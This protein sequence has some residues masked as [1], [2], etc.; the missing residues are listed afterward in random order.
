[1]NKINPADY[2][3]FNNSYKIALVAML[4]ENKDI[5][6]TLLS[7][8]MNKE[9][10]KMMFGEF[11]TG[12]GKKYLAEN[13]KAG[14][15]IMNV[16][17]E[18]WTGKMDYTGFVTEGEDYIHF[19]EMPLYRYNTYFGIHK[20]H[21]ADLVDISERAKLKMGG[22]VLNAIKVALKKGA[23]AGENKGI[24]HPWAKKFL[25]K[26]DGLMFIAYLGGDG[27]PK[28]VPVIQGQ[29]ASDS[30]I[31][32]THAP[33]SD[34]LTDLKE[35]TNTALFG[36]SLTMEAV[37]VKG[38]Y[39]KSKGGL[40]YVDIEKVYN[41]MPPKHGQVYPAKPNVAVDFQNGD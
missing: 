8:L 36:L 11:V 18:F 32:F 34:M 29:A 13:P 33:Y 17:K 39:H 28:I 12:N 5:H 25:S 1:M 23:V 38:C 19:N 41:P 26:L 37:L 4:D 31:V 14:F 16:D 21:Y 40:C 30:R 3:D 20:V 27:Y 10:D 6:V 2:K 35:G 7:S 22:I 15:L 24:L 9:D